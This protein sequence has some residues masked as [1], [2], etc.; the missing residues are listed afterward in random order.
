MKIMGFCS[1]VWLAAFTTAL[2]ATSE[3]VL[4]VKQAPNDFLKDA[5]PGEDA[6]LAANPGWVAIVGLVNISAFAVKSPN[7]LAVQGVDGKALRTIIEKASV[8]SEFD[9]GTINSL[10]LIVFAPEDVAARGGLKLV[11]GGNVN[12]NN[13][14][15]ERLVIHAGSAGRY[16]VFAIEEAPKGDAG[17]SKFATIEVIVDD[18]ADKY[19]YWYLL[20]IILIGGALLARRLTAK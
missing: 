15:V 2:S 6:V 16:K 5:I 12:A 18:Y 1:L 7:N 9:D 11:W 4:V 10:K 3:A 14:Q 13:A 17:S 20:P 19:Y 8:Y